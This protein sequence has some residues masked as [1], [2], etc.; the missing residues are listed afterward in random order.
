MQTGRAQL[1]S[2]SPDPATRAG[3]GER[4]GRCPAEAVPKSPGRSVGAAVVHQREGCSLASGSRVTRSR[5]TGVPRG[6]QPSAGQ[7]QPDAPHRG[8][9]DTQHPRHPTPHPDPQQAQPQPT[10]AKPPHRGTATRNPYPR[11]PKQRNPHHPPVSDV[12]NPSFRPGPTDAIRSAP[13]PQN[14]VSPPTTNLPARRRRSCRRGWCR[15]CRGFRWGGLRGSRGVVLRGWW[16]W[17]CRIWCR[18]SW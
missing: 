3:H 9:P 8:T 12:G 17:W 16:R 10:A 14:A 5:P 11:V 13:A 15:W 1:D 6:Y 7:H 4:P 2:F 18:L